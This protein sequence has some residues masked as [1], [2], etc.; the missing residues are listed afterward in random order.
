MERCRE[1]MPNIALAITIP[2]SLAAGVA[3]ATAKRQKTVKQADKT[4]SAGDG[5]S[6]RVV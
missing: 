1:K 6:R 2:A 3:G 4:P 5:I